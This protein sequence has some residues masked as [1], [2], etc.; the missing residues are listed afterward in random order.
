MRRLSAFLLILPALSFLISACEDEPTKPKTPA[1]SKAIYVLNSAATSISVIDL[2]E[3]KV[4]NNVQTVGTWPNQL[5][6]RNGYL[7]CVN[8]G[9]NNIMKFDV[10][11][12]QAQPPVALGTGKNP[13]NMV[14]YN[15]Q[16]AYV[17]CSMSNEVLRVDMTNNTVVKTIKAGVGATGIEIANSKVYV[18]NTG[19]AGWG[20]PYLTGTV[21][22][23]NA[24]TGDSLRTI[25]V[26]TNPQSIA[27]AKDG[28]LHVSCTGDYGA[29]PGV[30]S[31]IDPATDTV[32]QT[33]NIGGSPGLIALAPDAKLG[34]LSVWGAGALVYNT[35]TYAVVNGPASMWLG[36]G[37]SG[38]LVDTDEHIWLSV[39]DDDQVVKAKT[40]GTILATY[41]VG[42]S[43]A[44]LA[45]KID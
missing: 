41:N 24:A 9:S 38:I 11:N 14:F 19:Y 17:A 16:Y 32:V 28:K 45:Q 31:V 15:N 13:M 4:Y 42:D 35:S 3:D 2:T 27:V 43:P 44:A 22:V 5:V 40:D 7:Y 10:N 39:W 29:I 1:V 25:K 23:I 21:T 34:F 37:G 33:V 30:V 6:Y 36:K 8:S 18:T 26:G 12:W 20:N